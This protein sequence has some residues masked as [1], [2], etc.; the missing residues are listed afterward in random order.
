MR[1][2]AS[3][4]LRACDQKLHFPDVGVGD[5]L[6]TAANRTPSMSGS[7]WNRLLPSP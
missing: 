7:I 3:A 2:T 4:S 1:P 6:A 5:F